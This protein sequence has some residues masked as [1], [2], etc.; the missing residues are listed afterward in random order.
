VTFVIKE[1]FN[2][3]LLRNRS[4]IA[5]ETLEVH[6]MFDT[7][8]TDI[9]REFWLWL[10]NFF[11]NRSAAL[12][13]QHAHKYGQQISSRSLR[14]NVSWSL[15]KTQL[16][17]RLW[18]PFFALFISTWNQSPRNGDGGYEEIPHGGRSSNP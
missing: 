17:Q 12:G 7:V 16:S 13:L 8:K 2:N 1:S 4:S 3:I 11:G 5:T 10:R 6:T 9:Q 14:H 15:K 18:F